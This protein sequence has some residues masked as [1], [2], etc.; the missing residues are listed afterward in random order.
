MRAC[1]S[2]AEIRGAHARNL[3]RERE[4]HS[5][6]PPSETWFRARDGS[7]R[8]RETERRNDR[9]AVKRPSVQ[10]LDL[11]V[12]TAALANPRGLAFRR[13]YRHYGPT[14]RWAAGTRVLRWPE[15]TSSFDDIVQDVWVELLRPRDRPLLGYDAARGATFAVFLAFISSRFAWKIAKRRLKHPV[16]ELHDDPN[17]ASW[18][19]TH[20]LMRADVLDRLAA[21][22]DT[23][24]ERSRCLFYGHFVQGRQIREVG[25]ELGLSDN[26]SHVFKRRFEKKLAAIAQQMLG[27]DQEPPIEGAARLVALTLATF[28]AL[29]AGDREDDQVSSQ[30]PAGLVGHHD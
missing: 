29:S 26:A 12:V 25:A 5:P 3:D 2:S 11:E 8:S 21:R 28:V 6:S 1:S 22:V 23:M 24:D 19:F 9:V 10:D 7:S 16:E 27:L 17:D 13:F 30:R 4:R 20:D 15:L 18:D 14:V